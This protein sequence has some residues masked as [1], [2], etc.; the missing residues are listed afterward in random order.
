MTIKALDRRTVLR[1]LLATGGAVTI[2]LPLLEIM[3]NGNGTA[4]AQTGAAITVPYVTWFFGNGCSPEKWKP[5]VT[6]T[7]SAWTLSPQLQPLSE[8]KSYLTVISGL[9]NKCVKGGSEHPSGSAGAT[10]GSQ[11]NGNAVRLKSID[12]VVADTIGTGTDFKS[13]EVGVTPATPNGPEDSLHSVSHRGPSARNDAEYDP[14]KVFTKLFMGGGTT[15]TP[16]TM[17]DAMAKLNGVKKSMLDSCLEDGAALQKRLGASDK[18]RVQDH[19]DSIRAI[20]ARLQSM[21][22]PTSTAACTSPTAPT[23]GSDTKS[24][25]PPAVN[26]AMVELSALAL[27]CEKTRVLTY[28]FSLPAAHVYYRHVDTDMNADFHDTICHGDGNS[29]TT[30]PRVEKGVQYVLK[31]LNEFL[32]KFNATAFGASNLLDASLIYVTSDTAWGKIHTKEEWPVLLVGKAGGKLQGDMHNNYPADNLSKVL[33]TI[34]KTMGS[35][36]TEIGLDNGNVNAT[37]SGIIA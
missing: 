2:P 11:L 36:I 34:A 13:L 7:G 15:T 32:T 1:G 17:P 6:G 10:T 33:F 23:I 4:L 21:A 5:A 22:P 18:K 24:E 8:F 26:T 30:Q 27:A 28:M 19:L 37:L 3:L 14:K 16:G 20:E 35:P 9:T 12:Q 25:A 29:Q 31:S